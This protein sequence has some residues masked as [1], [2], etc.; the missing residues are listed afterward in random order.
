MKAIVSYCDKDGM[1]VIQQDVNIDLSDMIV[2][3]PIF[4]SVSFNTGSILVGTDLR[5]YVKEIRIQITEVDDKTA[6]I[7]SLIK[8]YVDQVYWIE[9][10]KY[11]RIPWYHPIKQMEAFYNYQFVHVIRELIKKVDKENDTF[12]QDELRV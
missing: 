11:E 6:T 8:S 9:K 3:N 5:N 12:R 7:L 1:P 10:K 2:L 4:P